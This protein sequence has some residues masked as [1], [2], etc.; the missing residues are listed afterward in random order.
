MKYIIGPVA[1]GAAQL[2]ERK[3]LILKFA[4]SAPAG[5]DTFF[6]R[7][8]FG[9]SFLMWAGLVKLGKS[10]ASLDGYWSVL[11]AVAIE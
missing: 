3:T 5:D 7:R 6:L 10:A 9:L 11:L 2:I 4:S 8:R 1:S